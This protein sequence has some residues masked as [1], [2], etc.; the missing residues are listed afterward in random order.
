M[1]KRSGQPKTDALPEVFFHAIAHLL[2]GLNQI[3]Q[4]CDIT[5]G[6]WIIMWQLQQAKVTNEE[7]QPIMLRQV[8]TDLLAKRGFGDANIV[9]LLNGLE[10]KDLVRRVSLTR[11]E[12][13]RLFED[14]EGGNRQAVILQPSGDKKIEQFKSQL[15]VH[16]EGWRSEQSV[17]LQT[18]LASA[19]GAGLQIAE[20]LMKEPTSKSS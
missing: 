11:E 5:I 10:D 12:R 3:A 17:M 16:F 4:E 9:R 2:P 15:A 1:S 18:A 19:K 13:A 8:L 14:S 20:W 7:G 6:Q